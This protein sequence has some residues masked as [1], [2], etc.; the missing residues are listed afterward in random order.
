M[1]ELPLLDERRCTGCGDCVAVCPTRCLEMASP[2]PWLPR[3]LECVSCSL[4]V[5]LCPDDALRM[6]AVLDR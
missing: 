3:P 2:L 5:L 4:C 1:F 6:T